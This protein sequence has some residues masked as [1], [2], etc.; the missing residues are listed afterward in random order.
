MYFDIGVTTVL[1]NNT[2]LPMAKYIVKEIDVSKA[3]HGFND[4]NA[5]KRVIEVCENY[6][7]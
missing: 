5:M 1:S 7:Y 3:P 4:V 2:R 6:L